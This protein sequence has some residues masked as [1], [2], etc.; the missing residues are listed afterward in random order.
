MTRKQKQLGEPN[1]DAGS[2]SALPPPRMLALAE[3][4]DVLV[5]AAGDSPGQVLAEQLGT[6]RAQVGRLLGGEVDPRWST[7]ERMVQAL[8]S[9]EGRELHV[10]LLV[11]ESPS[12][13]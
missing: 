7:I 4:L 8:G 1:Q 6:S 9:L 5:A 11:V 3:L 13:R 2:R 12:S 10:L